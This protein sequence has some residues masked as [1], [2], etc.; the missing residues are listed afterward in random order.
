MS[1]KLRL[2]ILFSLIG[3]VILAIGIFSL[4]SY[5]NYHAY[6]QSLETVVNLLNLFTP[7]AANASSAVK[8]YSAL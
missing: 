1:K 2:I 6:R 7:S 3:A 5:L 8:H 4:V